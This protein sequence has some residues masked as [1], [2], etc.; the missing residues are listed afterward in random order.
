MATLS[1]VR[2]KVR[3]RADIV[4]ETKRYPNEELDVYINDSYKDLYMRL[5]RA[6]LLREERSF[7]IAADGSASYNVPLDHMST[8]AVFFEGSGDHYRRLRHHDFRDRPFGADNAVTGEAGTYREAKLNGRKQIELF[9]RPGAGTYVL[10]YVPEPE[11]LEDDDDSL[12]AVLDWDEYVVIC[13]AIKALRKE[14]SDT[15]MLERDRAEKLDEIVAAANAQNMSETAR[16][17]DTRMRRGGH[18]S[19]GECW[20]AASYRWYRNGDDF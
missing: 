5:T 10:S 20:D 19:D 17:R 1:E 4:G 16:V 18:F 11:L 12:D 8:L 9:P 2:A 6:S 7:D 15:S 3:D 13:A 14:D